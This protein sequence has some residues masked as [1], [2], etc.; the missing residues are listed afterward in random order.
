MIK[1][2]NVTFKYDKV[3]LDNINLDIDKFKVTF[4]IGA[5]GSGKSTLANVISGLLFPNSGKIYLDDI[6]LNKKTNNKIIRKKIQA[7]KYYF[8]KY[9]MI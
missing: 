7:I 9:M 3:V 8:Q 5:N 1:L 6:E 4:I 2:K